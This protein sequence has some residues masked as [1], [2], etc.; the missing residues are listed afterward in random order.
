[1]PVSPPLTLLANMTIDGENDYW[2]FDDNTGDPWIGYPYRWNVTFSIQD[3]LHSNQTTQTPDAFNGMDVQVGDWFASGLGGKA[4]RIVEITTPGYNTMSCIVEDYERYN[5]LSDP[6]QTGL[7]ICDAGPGVIFRLS[8]DGLPVI[9]PIQEYYL[10]TTTITDLQARFMARNS[11]S[12]FVLVNQHNHGMDLGYVIVAD[13]DNP[14][15]YKMTDSTNIQHA[16]GIV[17]EIN[18]PGLDYFSYR[19]MGRLIN[20]VNPPLWGSHGTIFYLDPSNAGQLT[21]DKPDQNPIPV[22]MQLDLPTRAIMLERGVEQTSASSTTAKYDVTNLSAGQTQFTM[23]AAA[24]SVLY[25]A[26]NG[27]ENED[28]TFDTSSKVLVFD[29]VRTGYGVDVDDEVFFIYTT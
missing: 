29:P 5:L 19:P 7:G 24:K 13:S 20:N 12:S 27:V 11:V 6:N 10:A 15:Q 1:M 17:T 22:Y 9:G 23:P 28:F 25:M 18:V 16:I 21:T 3:Q 2:N 8:D 14:G 26:I 4:N